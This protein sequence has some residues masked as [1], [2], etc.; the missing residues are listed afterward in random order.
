MAVRELA[1]I[2]IRV[3]GGEENL[4]DWSFSVNDSQIQSDESG[5][6]V[7][8]NLTRREHD[9][10]LHLAQG[11]SAKEVAI[12]LAITARTVESHIDRLRLKTRT[13]NRTHMVAHAI[14]QGLL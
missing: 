11:L 10:L 4:I 3:V 9:V 6:I 2:G 1:E 12:R 7:V 13:R 14:Q 5:I 8:V